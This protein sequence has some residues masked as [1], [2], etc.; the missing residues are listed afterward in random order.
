MSTSKSNISA[1]LASERQFCRGLLP[2]VY[3]ELRTTAPRS[4]SDLKN[5]I[6][7]FTGLDIPLK[8]VCKGHSSPLDY[9]WHSFSE[10]FQRSGGNGDCI[11]WANRGGGKTLLAAAATLLDCVFKP[12]CGVR[13]LAGSQ[14]Q[15]M[16]MYDYLS[17][18]ITDG[19]EDFLDG[20]IRAGGC[21]FVNGSDVEVLTQSHSSVRGQ[22]IQKLRCDELELFDRSVFEASKFV[23]CSRDNIRSSMELIS[24][25]HKPYGLMQEQ[26]NQADKKG[27]PVFKWCVWDV[28]E[29]CKARSCSQ[30]PLC[31]DCR[32]KAK[33]AE[34]FLKI[35]DCIAQ[36]KRASRAGWQAEMLCEKPNLENAVFAEFDVDVHIDD[37]NYN[38]NLGLYRAI[39]FGFVN[40]FVCLW[41]QVD[42]NGV[43][44]VFDEYVK[45][46][47]TVDNHCDKIKEL[48]PC[49]EQKVIGTFCDPAGNAVN[50]MTG[51]SPV[52]MMRNEGINV[53][54]CSSGINYGIELI[55]RALKSGNGKSRLVISSRCRKLIEA[56]Q[57]YHYPDEPG[58]SELPLKDGL[59]D[60]YIDALRY[61]FVNYN[62]KTQPESRRY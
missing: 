11:V 62:R 26:I 28:I 42:D 23:T 3:D 9:L 31:S 20:K 13:I 61:F 5:Y 4:K 17:D 52:R 10:D 50:D 27:I 44:R 1:Q 25:M 12:G 15:A 2:A 53:S 39:D 35:D 6:K 21:R 51:T 18:F 7:I 34:G 16:N 54:Y 24:T 58:D 19:Y 48:T 55:R 57:C 47:V 32:G 46:R 33:R 59:Y 37:V 36:I 41:I 40:P 45:R 30:C 22:H 60:H 56:L 43:V 29:N 49:G 14:R 8:S 38:E